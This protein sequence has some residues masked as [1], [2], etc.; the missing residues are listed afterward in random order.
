MTIKF[1]PFTG[2][3]DYVNGG[4]DIAGHMSHHETPT[5]A[6][7]GAETVFTTASDYVSG[8]LKVFLDGLV[9]I[10][11]TDYSETTSTTFTMA[12]APDADEVLW[13]EYIKS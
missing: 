13:V 8:T 3:M 11:D 6:T 5:P 2:T 12:A 7:D 4:S 9:Q 10:K 1:N